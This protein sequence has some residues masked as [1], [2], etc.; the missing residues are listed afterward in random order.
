MLDVAFPLHR[1]CH[2]WRFTV[3]SL[4]CGRLQQS[5]AIYEVE[6]DFKACLAD[7]YAKLSS[8]FVN[9]EHRLLN[10]RSRKE[11]WLRQSSTWVI[12]Y[13]VCQT[14]NDCREARFGWKTCKLL[15]FL[16][17]LRR[18]FLTTS[19]AWFAFNMNI[20]IHEVIRNAFDKIKELLLKSYDIEI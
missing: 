10:C 14:G 6:D 19:A 16:M 13:Q 7:S 9:S 2:W 12:N 15:G 5:R 11:T 4:R 1:L 8:H 3:T 18:M 17:T 20:I